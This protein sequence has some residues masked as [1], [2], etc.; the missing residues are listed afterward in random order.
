MTGEYKIQSAKGLFISSAI[1]LIIFYL[2][3]RMSGLMIFYPLPFVIL[4]ARTSIVYGLG[5]ILLSSLGAFMVG[6]LPSGLTLITYGLLFALPLGY[7]LKKKKTV[8]WAMVISILIAFVIIGL[9]FLYLGQDT[10]ESNIEAIRQDVLE[11]IDEQVENYKSLDLGL[12]YDDLKGTMVYIVDLVLASLP[13][14]ILLGLAIISLVNYYLASGFLRSRGV[15]SPYFRDYS[16]PRDLLIGLLI[17][18]AAYGILNYFD[19]LYLNEFG[20][21]TFNVFYNLFFIQGLASAYEFLSK[22][23][24]ETSTF[25]LM[26]FTFVFGL[27]MFYASI[28]LVKQLMA[29]IRGGADS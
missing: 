16:L 13:S 6:G 15:D 8:N 1:G 3:L 10:V 26:T 27:G 17:S 12:S 22:R 21:N 7:S 19:F 18:L 14:M 5:A 28:G 20:I 11:N 25:L 2:S 29:N 9:G 24:T 23:F 4:L